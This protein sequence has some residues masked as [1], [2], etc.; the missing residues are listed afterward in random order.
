MKFS[1]DVPYFSFWKKSCKKCSK[2]V[3]WPTKSRLSRTACRGDLFIQS[4]V[5]F[6]KNVLAFRFSASWNRS[7]HIIFSQP[8]EWFRLRLIGLN[9]DVSH[10]ALCLITK[11]HTWYLSFFLHGQHFNRTL[12]PHRKCV[13][14]DKTGFATKQRK[15]QQNRFWDKKE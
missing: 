4:F 2:T 14:C 9:T 12:S 13:N 7:S 8:N 11:S 10:Q 3:R 6:A 5:L 15:L 1:I